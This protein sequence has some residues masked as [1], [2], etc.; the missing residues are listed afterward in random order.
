METFLGVLRPIRLRP[1]KQGIIS[2]IHAT[3]ARKGSEGTAPPILNLRTLKHSNEHLYLGLKY[4]YDFYGDTSG[5]QS[6]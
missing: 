1:A 3:R 6:F 2:P 4:T 5:A